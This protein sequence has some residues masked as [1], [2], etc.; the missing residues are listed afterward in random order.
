MFEEAKCPVCQGVTEGDC[1]VFR[2]TNWYRFKCEACGD[3]LVEEDALEDILLDPKAMTKVQRSALSHH[4]AKYG[5]S[6]KPIEVTSTWL[7]E[8]LKDARLIGPDAQ[9]VNLRGLIGDHFVATAEAYTAWEPKTIALIGGTDRSAFR[10]LIEHA[11][12]IGHIQKTGTITPNPEDITKFADAYVLTMAGW[13]AYEAEKKGQ[14]AGRY[15]F[16]AMQFDDPDLQPLFKDIIKPKVSEA[17]GYDVVEVRE[18]SRAGVIDN[19]IREEI[20]NAAFVLADLSHG[21][22]GAYWEAGYAEGLGKPVIYLCEQKTFDKTKTH[23]DTNH[24]TTVMWS[25]GEEDLFA[26]QLIATIQRSLLLRTDGGR[27]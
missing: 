8:F 16:M 26:E 20:R 5:V 4:L 22:N 25:K 21:N 24:C 15:G 19:I 3:Y 14:L 9:L 1:S 27:A 12:Q 23:F 17:T 10:R 13:A 2:S 6:K 7:S 18:K 11:L